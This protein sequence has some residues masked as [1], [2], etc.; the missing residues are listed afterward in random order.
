MMATLITMHS[1]QSSTKPT[2]LSLNRAKPAL[3]NAVTA[4]KTPSQSDSNRSEPVSVWKR[5]V[6]T[7]AVTPSTTAL[8]DGDADHD[9]AH[10]A[11][12]ERAG[13]GL[14]DQPAAQAQPTGQHAGPRAT[15]AS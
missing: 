5:H 10:V 15:T 12:V 14:G 3:L 1:H 2:R 6:S 11:G 9:P 8:I 13:L 7:T 4:W